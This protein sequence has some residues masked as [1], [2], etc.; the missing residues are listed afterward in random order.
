MKEDSKTTG[1]VK[2]KQVATSTRKDKVVSTDTSSRT[3]ESVRSGARQSTE[4]ANVAFE[5]QFKI[6]LTGRYPTN[7]KC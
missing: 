1:T 7:Q 3:Q 6:P 2:F 4:R 5:I